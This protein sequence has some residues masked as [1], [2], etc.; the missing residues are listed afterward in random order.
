MSGLATRAK[1]GRWI[2]AVGKEMKK[3]KV[4]EK[5]KVYYAQSY[6][7][8]RAINWWRE[9]EVAERMGVPFTWGKLKKEIQRAIGLIRKE[10]ESKPPQDGKDHGSEPNHKDDQENFWSLTFSGAATQGEAIQWI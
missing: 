3:D 8:G 9:H 6:L 1:L 7:A 10:T 2:E 5:E 4:R